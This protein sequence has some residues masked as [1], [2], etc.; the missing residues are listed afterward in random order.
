L[1]M[2]SRFKEMMILS[3]TCLY[4]MIKPLTTKKFRSWLRSPR[5]KN[6]TKF[7]KVNSSQL[8]FTQIACRTLWQVAGTTL[9]LWWSPTRNKTWSGKWP[10]NKSSRSS[11]I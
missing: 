10:L 4:S 8:R 9:G 11:R 5:L 2:S 3:Q 7:K 6:W 1:W